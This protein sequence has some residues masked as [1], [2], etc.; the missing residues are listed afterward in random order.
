[1]KR[2]LVSGQFN[3]LFILYISTAKPFSL[4]R[5]YFEVKINKTGNLVSFDKA[6]FEMS[7]TYQGSFQS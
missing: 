1:M 2:V 3:G 5:E 6:N 7:E 4:V